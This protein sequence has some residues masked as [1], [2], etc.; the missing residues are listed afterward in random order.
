MCAIHT[1]FTFET[2]PSIE[3]IRDRLA[4]L[5]DQPILVKEDDSDNC[6]FCDNAD[7]KGVSAWRVA[8][9][10]VPDFPVVL[11]RC[12]DRH[13]MIAFSD[14]YDKTL[15]VMLALV[16]EAM[17]GH[18]PSVFSRQ[19]ADLYAGPVSEEVLRR[20]YSKLRYSLRITFFVTWMVASWA[21]IIW[22]FVLSYDLFAFAGPILLIGS[23]IALLYVIVLFARRF[24]NN[25]S[26]AAYC[27]PTSET[28]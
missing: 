20:R 11:C 4:S 27:N 12:D 25:G 16:L 2:A 10:C 8:F 7:E 21:L 15:F 24:D 26:P 14:L 22:L 28:S 1:V 23:F 13:I 6:L 18:S 9:A 3:A 5:S 19:Y 17:G